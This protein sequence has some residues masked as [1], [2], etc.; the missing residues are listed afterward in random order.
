[1]R[2]GRPGQGTKCCDFPGL[3]IGR[4]TSDL[5]WGKPIIIILSLLGI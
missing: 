2:D 5:V 4:K 3:Q 1:M